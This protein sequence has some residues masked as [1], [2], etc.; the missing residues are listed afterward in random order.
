MAT[1]TTVNHQFRL[2]SR[3]VGLVKREDFDYTEEPVGEPGEGEI[4]VK[5]LYISLDPA[6]RGWM[7]EGRSYVL[8][9]QLG[10]VMRSIDVAEVVA[11]S[12][13]KFAAGDHVV[14]VFGVQE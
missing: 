11:S 7:N 3:P 10:E 6:M 13:P 5:V 9:V 2:T 1:F 8:P 4:L 12:N 14:G